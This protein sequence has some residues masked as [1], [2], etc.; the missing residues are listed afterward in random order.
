MAKNILPSFVARQRGHLMQYLVMCFVLTLTTSCQT[1]DNLADVA[2]GTGPQI[3]DIPT[4]I[5]ATMLNSLPIQK[6][7]IRSLKL[8][9]PAKG[10]KVL[11]SSLTMRRSSY[12]SLFTSQHVSDYMLREDFPSSMKD[13][14]EQRFE[15]DPAATNEWVVE[16]SIRTKSSFVNHTFCFSWTVTSTVRLIVRNFDSKNGLPEVFVGSANDD[17]CSVA[18]MVPKSEDVGLVISRALID[19]VNKIAL[20]VSQ[21]EL[22]QKNNRNEF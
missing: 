13:V 12:G 5:P 21:S 10:S 22:V 20:K 3:V 2:N 7:K 18:A 17:F 1:L 4:E 6:I 8:S 11:K 16:S 19:A 14:M 9:G 15:L